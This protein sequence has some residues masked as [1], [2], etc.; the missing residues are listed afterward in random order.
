LFY[1]G[2]FFAFAGNQSVG[3]GALDVPMIRDVRSTSATKAPQAYF[4]MTCASEKVK[5]K[6]VSLGTFL[7]S[8]SQLNENK[9]FVRACGRARP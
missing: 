5:I 2:C 9:V 3:D 7:I 6:K 4:P 8:Y 1:S